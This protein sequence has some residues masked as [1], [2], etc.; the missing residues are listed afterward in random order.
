MLVP[1]SKIYHI[2]VL[3]YFNIEKENSHLFQQC[4]KC[5]NKFIFIIFLNMFSILNSVLSKIYKL[6]LN[7]I[8]FIS[9]A[10]LNLIIVVTNLQSF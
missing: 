8:E 9:A 7:Y 10:I 3:F 4:Q 2:Y 1:Y 5:K 6:I